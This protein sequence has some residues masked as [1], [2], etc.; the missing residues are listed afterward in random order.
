MSPQP[1][2]MDLSNR[3]ALRRKHTHFYK[4]QTAP[5]TKADQAKTL[6]IELVYS[7][8]DT[9]WKRAATERLQEV[10]ERYDT[11][12]S[13][14]IIEPLEAQGITTG[15]NRAIAAILKGAEKAGL[16]EPTDN[17]IA[18]KRAKAHSRPKRVWKVVRR[19]GVRV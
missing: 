15:D 12:T 17:F 1:T 3:E 9:A 4:G 6:G 14:D 10:V 18:T 2:W 16:I 11:F 5:M 13:D 7:H 8:A 19:P